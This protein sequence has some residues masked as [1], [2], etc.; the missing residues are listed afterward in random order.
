MSNF[1][2]CNIPAFG[3]TFDSVEHG[4]HFKKAMDHDLFNEAEII[5]SQPTA[6]EAKA[7]ADDLIG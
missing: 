4:Y 2:P 5:K 3:Q 7:K 6:K 1:F